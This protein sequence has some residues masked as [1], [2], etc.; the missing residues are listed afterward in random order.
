MYITLHY[1][2]GNYVLIMY[3]I[4]GECQKSMQVYLW[5][6]NSVYKTYETIKHINILSNIVKNGWWLFEMHL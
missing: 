1:K 3:Y 4:F 5:I 2:Q 6:S